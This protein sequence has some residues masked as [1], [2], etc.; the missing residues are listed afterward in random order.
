MSEV[1]INDFS[2]ASQISICTPVNVE[3]M[4]KAIDISTNSTP[5]QAIYCR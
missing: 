5:T 2:K 3:Q 1:L 4:V